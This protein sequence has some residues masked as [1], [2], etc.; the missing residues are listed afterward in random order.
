[1]TGA[2]SGSRALGQASPLREED[3]VG[4]S[5]RGRG[6]GEGPA[7]GAGVGEGTVDGAFGGGTGGAV[8]GVTA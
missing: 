2:T 6:P 5:P 4:F 8:A 1:M 7:A 3:E